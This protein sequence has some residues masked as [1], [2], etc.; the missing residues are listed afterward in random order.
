MGLI[1]MPG[2]LLSFG[3]QGVEKQAS[4]RQPRRTALWKAQSRLR[5]DEQP[6]SKYR[7]T[8]DHG[9]RRRFSTACQ[10]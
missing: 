5:R 9:L 2:Y 1:F 10:S 7:A 3:E 8:P 4:G 6:I